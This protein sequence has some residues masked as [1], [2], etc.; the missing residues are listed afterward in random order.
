MHALLGHQKKHLLASTEVIVVSLIWKS[1]AEDTNLEIMIH[2]L[3][4]YM[5]VKI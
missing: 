3:R 1:W 2:E 4:E 5:V